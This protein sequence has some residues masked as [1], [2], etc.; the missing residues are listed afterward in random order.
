[1][2]PAGNE[3]GRNPDME[4]GLGPAGSKD[5]NA[6]NEEK[7]QT[8]NLDLI[9]DID[10]EVRIELGR[11]RKKIREI[12]ELSEG[13]IVELDKLAGEPVDLLVNDKPFARG[14]VVVIDESFGVRITEIL[15]VK[16][17]I[18]SLA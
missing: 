1:M 8:Q 18:E 4:S 6:M 3:D 13:S 15:G 5:V 10:M 17:R 9:M 2:S 7:K 14:E 12:L 11:T 16:E